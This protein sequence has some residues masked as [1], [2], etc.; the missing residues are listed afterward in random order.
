VIK[1]NQTTPHFS[2]LLDDGSKDLPRVLTPRITIE[3]RRANSVGAALAAAFGVS[4]F[5]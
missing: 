4:A 5:A 3:L 1:K 2:Q